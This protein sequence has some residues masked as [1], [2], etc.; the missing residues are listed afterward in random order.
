[1]VLFDSD[2]QYQWRELLLIFLNILF[3]LSNYCQCKWKKKTLLHII[4]FWTKWNSSPLVIIM[5]ENLTCTWRKGFEQINSGIQLLKAEIYWSQM[6]ENT[7]RTHFLLL[8]SVL[9]QLYYL[10]SAFLS[11]FISLS[12][13]FVSH[14]IDY[15]CLKLSVFFL[16]FSLA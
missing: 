3:K 4:F 6:T 8:I 12:I 10:Q 7:R 11:P 13:L 16:S 5:H 15:L 1:M 14:C 2:L 9:G